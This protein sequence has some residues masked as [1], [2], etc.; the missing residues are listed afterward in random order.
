MD[1]L[2]EELAELR[3]AWAADQESLQDAVDCARTVRPQLGFFA[4]CEL[5]LSLNAP[6]LGDRPGGPAGSGGL[7]THGAH[8]AVCIPLVP[9]MSPSTRFSLMPLG[10]HII[11]IITSNVQAVLHQVACWLRRRMP[12]MTQSD[13]CV[14]PASP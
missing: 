14:Q 12:A 7:R 8:E 10:H 2:R 6:C 13:R 4:V 3:A 5:A 1:E 11:I 9:T